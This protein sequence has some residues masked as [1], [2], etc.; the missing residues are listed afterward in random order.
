M[1]P[2]KNFRLSGPNKAMLALMPKMTDPHYRGHFKR[3]LIQAQ[4]GEE[5]AKRAALKSKDG[6]KRN[7]VPVEAE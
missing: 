4:L 5:A 3:M 2:D 6:G 1:T 7:S